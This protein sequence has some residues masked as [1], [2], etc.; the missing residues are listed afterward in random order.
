MPVIIPV[1]VDQMVQPKMAVT[2]KLDHLNLTKRPTWWKEKTS[3][4]KLSPSD[5][6]P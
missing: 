3:S 2:M 5:L 4:Y 1:L 6:H